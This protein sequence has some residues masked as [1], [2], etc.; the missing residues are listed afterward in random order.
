MNLN[1]KNPTQQLLQQPEENLPRV[2]VAGA[3]FFIIQENFHFV[4]YL[5]YLHLV[6]LSSLLVF[7]YLSPT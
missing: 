2:L 3:D 6:P 5:A 1:M 7:M 4:R